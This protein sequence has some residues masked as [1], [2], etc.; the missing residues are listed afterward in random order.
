MPAPFDFETEDTVVVTGGTM[1]GGRYL[2]GETIGKGGMGSVYRATD[3]RTDREIAVKVLRQHATEHTVRRFRREAQL[4]DAISHPGVVRILDCGISDDQHIYLAMELLRGVTLLH[5]LRQ[6]APL[7]PTPVAEILDSAASALDAVHQA[8]MVHRDL[9]PSNIILT[10]DPAAPV[11]LIDFGIATSIALER[12]TVTG[13]LLGTPRFMAPEQLRDARSIDCRADVYALGVI[14]YV[15]LAA[16]VPFGG[17]PSEIMAAVLEGRFP[18]LTSQRR[19]VPALLAQVVEKAMSLEP[20]D[21]FSS[22]GAFARR[23]SA[24]VRNLERPAVTLAATQRLTTSTTPPPPPS[25]PAPE[26]PAKKRPVAAYALGGIAIVAVLGSALAL[27]LAG[28]REAPPEP[29]P[30]RFA[31]A[32]PPI[33]PPAAAGPAS[34]NSEGVRDLG[35]GDSVGTNELEAIDLRSDPSEAM[36]YR[37]GVII[38][39][40]PLRLRLEASAY[41]LTVRRPGFS[42]ETLLIDPDRR[43]TIDVALHEPRPERPRPPRH[44]MA[45]VAEEPPAESTHERRHDPIVCPWCDN[46]DC[47]CDDP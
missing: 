5:H 46:A 14:S 41:E 31:A 21:R 47:L 20:E 27:S 7:A 29:E 23:F 11:K 36:V 19:T 4:L 28:E 33:A 38:G 3:T 32:T 25:A 16:K 1:L 26:T 22:A 43:G 8:G 15:A 6:A 44:P 40:T 2:V 9:K 30:A 34:D 39:S 35:S 17:T 37:D 12:L 24:T 13:E 45:T 10:G 42:D 18:P